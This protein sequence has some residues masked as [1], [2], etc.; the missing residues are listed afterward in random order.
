M[1]TTVSLS[2]K[3]TLA[4]YGTNQFGTFAVVRLTNAGTRSITYTGYATN[5]PWYSYRFHMAGSTTNFCPFFCGTGLE[6]YVLEPGN[7]VDFKVDVIAQDHVEVCLSYTYPNDYR[8]SLG[9]AYAAAPRR[10]ARHLP[11]P[12]AARV[13]S[14]VINGGN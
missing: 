1:V 10:I 12:S 4:G 9:R 14:P 6:D 13:V 11:F 3:L 5:M 2:P 8:N 7:S